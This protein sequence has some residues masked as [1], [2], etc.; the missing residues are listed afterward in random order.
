MPSKR[1]IT[2]RMRALG[3]AWATRSDKFVDPNDP[4]GQRRPT[5]HVHPDASRPWQNAIRRYRTLGE[6]ET[7]IE[8]RWKVSQARARGDEEYAEALM[9][10]EPG[11]Y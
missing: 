11:C 9:D 4:M 8:W 2:R 7:Y 3:M 6:L 5:Y 1:R 10:I